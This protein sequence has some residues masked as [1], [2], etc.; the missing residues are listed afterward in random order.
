MIQSF[1]RGNRHSSRK[2]MEGLQLFSRGTLP[3]S[4]VMDSYIFVLGGIIRLS[5]RVGSCGRFRK[6]YQK[7][8]QKTKGQPMAQG[9]VAS[10]ALNRTTSPKSSPP[11]G[12]LQ[13][14]LC[15]AETRLA[16][17]EVGC[18]LRSIHFSRDNQVCHLLAD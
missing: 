5:L 6:Y 11:G 13:R 15:H 1:P 9:F 7:V 4:K 3:V 8:L 12:N 16:G 14:L 18:C 10:P 2:E 17:I